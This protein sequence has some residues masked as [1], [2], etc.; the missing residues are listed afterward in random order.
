MVSHEGAEINTQLP[1]RPLRLLIAIVV[2]GIQALLLWG[3]AVWSIVAL[4]QGDSSSLTSSL[5]LSGMVLA[6]ALWASNIVFGLVRVRRWSHTAALVLQLVAAAIATAT[7]SGE[8]AQPQIGWPLLLAA[9]TAFIA[10]FNGEI[11]KQFFAE[12]ATD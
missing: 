11:R 1:K 12:G 4:L 5:F 6:A 9:L 10:L 2:V 3:I 8:F 7:L